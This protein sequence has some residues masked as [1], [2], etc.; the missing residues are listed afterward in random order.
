MPYIII[1]LFEKPFSW[2]FHEINFLRFSFF[3]PL[4]MLLDHLIDGG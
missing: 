4:G 1:P 2:A 3:V